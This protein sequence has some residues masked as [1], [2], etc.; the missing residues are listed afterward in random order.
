VEAFVEYGLSLSRQLRLSLFS[1]TAYFDA[2]YQQA[3]VKSGGENKRIDGNKVEGVPDWISRNGLNV[4]IMKLSLSVLYSYTAAS[5]ADPLNTVVPSATGSVGKVP[6]YGLLD[7]NMSLP[8]TGFILIRLN[9]NN[10]TDVH[11]FT[12]RPTFYPGPGI[13]PSDGRSVN[14]SVAVRF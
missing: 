13:W 9:V 10:L 5:F 14:V 2:R 1:S 12:K 6:A 7:L 11:Y 3:S 4:K 8:V